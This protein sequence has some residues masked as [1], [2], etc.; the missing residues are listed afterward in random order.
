[1][2]LPWWGEGISL[3]VSFYFFT[4]T[5]VNYVFAI[6]QLKSSAVP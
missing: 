6:C 1:M 2:R 5:I 4:S 3:G